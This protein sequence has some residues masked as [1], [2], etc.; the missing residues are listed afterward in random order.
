MEPNIETANENNPKIQLAGL[1]R[2]NRVHIRRSRLLGLDAPQK[3]DIQGMYRTG[4]EE[5]SA[6]RLEHQRLLEAM[7]LEE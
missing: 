6:A 3:L 7:T 1:D 4:T 2:L 5:M